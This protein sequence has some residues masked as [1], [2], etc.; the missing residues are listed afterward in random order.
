MNTITKVLLLIIIISSG[1]F[2]KCSSSSK[3]YEIMLNEFTNFATKKENTFNNSN[4]IIEVFDYLQFI[5]EHT[6][7]TTYWYNRIPTWLDSTK[8]KFIDNKIVSKNTIQIAQR[9]LSEKLKSEDIREK[10]LSLY[11]FTLIPDTMNISLIK[12]N[13]VLDTSGVVDQN[14]LKYIIQRIRINSQKNELNLFCDHTFSESLPYGKYLENF[15]K[16]NIKSYFMLRIDSDNNI[17][18]SDKKIENVFEVIP[19]NSE[20][21]TILLYADVASQWHNILNII[22]QLKSE[23]E[24]NNTNIYLR[25]NVYQGVTLKPDRLGLL[26]SSN[27]KTNSEK[28]IPDVNN[29]N[30]TSVLINAQGFIAVDWNIGLHSDEIVR[31]CKDKDVELTA[32]EDLTLEKLYPV[33]SLIKSAKPSSLSILRE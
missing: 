26:L 3:Q 21:K 5:S 27:Y 7:D 19:K 11:I 30:K 22:D 9:I 1:L 10:Y 28:K 8:I 24:L 33:L 13:I 15:P 6:F 25:G 32:Y 31:A 2:N 29:N 20:E 16:H 18:S 17:L 4:Q 23:K 12:K 14:L